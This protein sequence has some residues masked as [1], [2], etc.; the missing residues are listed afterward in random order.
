ML[1]SARLSRRARSS[2]AYVL[3]S[4]WGINQG[5]DAYFDNFDLSRYKAVRSAR[6]Q[7]PRQRGRGSGAAVDRR[8]G[9]PFFAW[10]HLYDA[11][12][13]YQPPEPFKPS[14]RRHPYT[15]E[16]AFADAQVGRLSCSL[17]GIA[18][19]SIA[20][21]S[22]CS[23]ITARA[24]G[25]TGRRTAVASSVYQSTLHVPLDHPRAIQCDARPPRRRRR[26]LGRR[27][28]D[29][30]RSARRAA[31]SKSAIGGP[32]RRSANDGRA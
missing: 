10:M 11:H 2:R 31:P 29:R 18:I 7:R 24:C 26:S 12:S 30:A 22:S 4:K 17:D 23:A 28:A 15:G 25:I 6:I 20:R 32:E 3:D 19:C 16:I 21:S 13:P 27:D 9:S 8:A 5:F 14:T 1:K